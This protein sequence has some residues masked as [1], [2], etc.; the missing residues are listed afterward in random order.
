MEL[1][2][3]ETTQYRARDKFGEIRVAERGLI[4]FLYF[5]HDTQQSATLKGH[6]HALIMKYAQAMSLVLLFNPAPARV[7]IIGLGGGSLVN[8]LLAT[9]PSTQVDVIELRPTVVEIAHTYFDVPRNHPR[10]T[11][12]IGDVHETLPAFTTE[13]WNLILSDAFDADGPAEGMGSRVHARSVRRLLEPTGIACFNLWNRA[14]DNFEAAF[15]TITET[16]RGR[17]S[18]YILGTENSNALA[19]AFASAPMALDHPILDQ[20]A[21]VFMQK[22]GINYPELLTNLRHLNAA[23]APTDA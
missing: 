8:F 1:D 19:L 10:L 6:T 16:F 22:T 17:T 23:P 20:R 21:L 18:Q 11:I 3:H 14:H 4:R 7:L 13:R 15:Q 2:A 12:T 9:F 5:G